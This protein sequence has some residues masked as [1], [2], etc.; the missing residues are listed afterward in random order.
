MFL[1]IC[2][3]HINTSFPES[4]FFNK[5]AVLRAC[6]SIIK[7][8]SDASVPVEFANFLRTIILKNICERLLLNFIWKETPTQVFSCKFSELFKNIYFAEDQRTAGSETSGQGSLFNKVARLTVWRHLTVLERDSSTGIS[9]QIL[10]NV[11]GKLCVEHVLATTFHM[12]LFFSSFLQIR[13]V[14]SLKLIYLVE[15]WW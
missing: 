2:K 14:Y 13:E 7:E 9:Q 3:I 5:V 15:Q 6:N 12:M 11:L 10:Q 8:D 1:K 4:L